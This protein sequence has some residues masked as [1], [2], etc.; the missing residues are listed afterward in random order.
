MK[1]FGFACIFFLCFSLF[2]TA[3]LSN[4][5]IL[6]VVPDFI[7][8]CSLYFSLHNGRFF[9]TC[10]GFAGGF[11]L[12]FFSAVP[13]G[14]NSLIRTVIGYVGGIFN[15]TLNI[16]GILFPFILGISTTLF[17]AFTIWCVSLFYPNVDV[18]YTLISKTFG[19]ELLMNGVLTPVLFRFLDIFANEIVLNPEKVK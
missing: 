2:E 19:F 13:F 18:S 1:S 6:P 9:G 17:K 16:N 5:M 7:L 15:K 8:I 4:I 11:I 3:V 14:F 12:D 10:A